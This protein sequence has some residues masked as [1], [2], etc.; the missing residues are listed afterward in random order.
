MS[1]LEDYLR[2]MGRIR[3]TGAT[4]PETSYYPT[5]ANLLN[6]IGGGLKPKVRCILHPSHG[7]GF[8]DFGLWSAEQ[9]GKASAEEPPIGVK[10]ARGVI[11]VKP[12]DAEVIAV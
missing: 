12:P 9:L 4:T 6:A 1:P 11:E 2:E 3:G 7:V 8:P 5:L 10:P